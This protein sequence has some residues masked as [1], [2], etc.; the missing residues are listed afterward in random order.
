M[1]SKISQETPENQIIMLESQAQQ[2]FN[3]VQRRIIVI[4]IFPN[5][6]LN[7]SYWEKISDAMNLYGQIKAQADFIRYELSRK[8]VAA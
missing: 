8:E 7:K 4:T 3:S 5:N 2:I 1:H 6:K